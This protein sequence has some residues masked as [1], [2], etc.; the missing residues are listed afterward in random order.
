MT[1]FF[2]FVSFSLFFMN[3]PQ[4][5]YVNPSYLSFG[6]LSSPCILGMN[7]SPANKNLFIIL[8]ILY[9]QN[10]IESNI[11]IWLKDVFILVPLNNP[12]ASCSLINFYFLLPQTAQFDRSNFRFFSWQPLG[13]ACCFFYTSNNKITLLMSILKVLIDWWIFKANFF[14]HIMVLL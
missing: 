4:A 12:L 2:T 10:K 14:F 3:I 11:G 7:L 8:F 13:F 1:C 5:L 6:C 9:S